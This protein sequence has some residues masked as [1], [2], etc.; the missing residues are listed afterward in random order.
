VILQAVAFGGIFTGYSTARDARDFE[1]G[2]A[3][4]LFLA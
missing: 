3:P 4:R 1:I 2:F